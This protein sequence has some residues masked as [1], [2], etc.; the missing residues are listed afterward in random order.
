MAPKA[1]QAIENNELNE[2]KLIEI[3]LIVPSPFPI[4]E[5]RRKRFNPDKMQELADSIARKGVVQPITVRQVKSGLIKYQIVAGERRWSASGIAGKTTVPCIVRELSDQ[6]ALEIQL[7]ENIERED[8]HPID[9]SDAYQFFAETY[10]LSIHE[11]ALRVGKTDSYIANRL[12]LKEAIPEVLKDFE[13]GFLPFGSVLEIVKYSQDIQPLILEKAY[14]DW[15]GDREAGPET[16]KDLRKTI[17]ED[18]L[19]ELENA[20]FSKKSTTLLKTGLACLN[21]PQRTG[22]NATLFGEQ[23]AKSDRCLN[24]TCYDQKKHN[25]ILEL[26]AKQSI[27]LVKDSGD[28]DARIPLVYWHRS[29]RQ[30]EFPDALCDKEFKKVSGEKCKSAENALQVD[31]TEK[32]QTILICRDINCK[33]HGI[34]S[35]NSS[36]KTPEAE[37]ENKLIRKEE[38]FDI[39]VVEGES[40]EGIGTG[41]RRRVLVEA[42]LKTKQFAGFT[43]E[44]LM[45]IILRLWRLED[46]SRRN[47]LR[48]LT[49][50]WSKKR[51]G[52]GENEVDNFLNDLDRNK[53]ESFLFLLLNTYKGEILGD[54]YNSQSEIIAI[55]KA[56]DIDYRLIDAQERLKWAEEKHKKHID[57]F[58]Q[59]LVAV[60]S[61]NTP[62]IP[63]PYSNKWNP[64]KGGEL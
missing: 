62:P 35:G 4:Q 48:K 12:K 39:R 30:K 50:D 34:G 47:V 46:N 19:L 60:E 45:E 23:T 31:G 32:L 22:A 43:A 8:L 64:E 58:K 26:Q 13:E 28:S 33:K 1:K 20:P 52:Y 10:N 41:L 37:S 3:G 21:C 49:Y 40:N 44:T 54:Y 42:A 17:Q 56:F 18:I 16:L 25:H 29:E 2:I 61:G 36:I 15:D 55:A 63:R 59:Y 9:E 38:L 5:R 14:K 6:D 11:I 27:N 53:Q 57:I 24:R 51:L 7:L